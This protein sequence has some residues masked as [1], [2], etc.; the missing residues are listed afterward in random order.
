TRH[1]M[2][3]LDDNGVWELFVP[4]VGAGGIY[5]FELLTASGE[6]VTRADPMARATEVPPSTG[7][8]ITDTHHEWADAAWMTQRGERDP[9]QGPMSVYEL[10]L[11][12]WKPGL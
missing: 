2:R 5:K 4:G 8:V 9:H 6:W 1:A 12:S 10:H 3:R 11:G 7:S